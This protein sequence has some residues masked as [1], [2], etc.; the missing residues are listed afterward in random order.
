MLIIINNDN[1]NSNNDDNSNNG[2]NNN[3]ENNNGDNNNGDN[4]DDDNCNKND[5]NNIGDNNNGDNGFKKP[6][7]LHLIAG[8]EEEETVHNVLGKFEDTNLTANASRIVESDGVGPFP[9]NDSKRTVI[10]LS[11]P[12]VHTVEIH[13][14]GKLSCDECCPRFVQYLICSHTIA[15]ANQIGK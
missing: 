10:S 11:K 3:G 4:N 15:V 2:D 7:A 12:T 8:D 9:N 1:S 5:D 14:N 13:K 6:S